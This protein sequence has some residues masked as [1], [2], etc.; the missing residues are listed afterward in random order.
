ML[1]HFGPS[2]GEVCQAGLGGLRGLGGVDHGLEL[3]V[4]DPPV[5]VL[6]RVR[7]HLLNVNLRHLSWGC[8]GGG[9]AG[10]CGDGES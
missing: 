8:S 7:E 6:V 5:T 4:A 9:V 3:G 10:E 1:Y 2:H